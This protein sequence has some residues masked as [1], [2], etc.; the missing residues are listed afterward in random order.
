M[1]EWS[2]AA[3]AELQRAWLERVASQL[4]GKRA[5]CELRGGAHPELPPTLEVRL[6]GRDAAQ[7]A[8]AIC[9]R[10]RAG[11]PP[12]YLGH[13]RLRDGMLLVSAAC[14]READLPAL[15]EALRRELSP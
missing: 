4:I 9:G 2:L 7:L 5:R 3:E 10:L 11:A 12:I 15:Q 6:L 1:N 8:F 14:L 13:A